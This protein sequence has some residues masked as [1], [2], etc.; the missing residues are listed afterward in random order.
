MS[1]SRTLFL[2][3]VLALAPTFVLGM[4]FLMVWNVT[5]LVLTSLILLVIDRSEGDLDAPEQAAGGGR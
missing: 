3:A 5:W 2:C 1:L 4:P